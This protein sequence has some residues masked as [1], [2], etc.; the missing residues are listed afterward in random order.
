MQVNQIIC[1]CVTARFTGGTDQDARSLLPQPQ[2]A[3]GTQHQGRF[4]SV[5][6]LQ[7]EPGESKPSEALVMDDASQTGNILS[8]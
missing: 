7:Q 3:V 8:V 1:V 5:G 6:V 2:P 4:H